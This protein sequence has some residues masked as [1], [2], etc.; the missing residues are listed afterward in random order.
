MADSSTVIA[1]GTVDTWIE[2]LQALCREVQAW[3]ESSGWKTRIILKTITET[4]LGRYRAPVLIMEKDAVEMVLNPVARYVPG[5]EGAVDLYLAPAYDDVATLYYEQST[6]YLHIPI[7]SQ[8]HMPERQ[9]LTSETFLSVLAEMS[10][11]G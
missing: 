10:H 3:A 6:W 9:P 5:A 11:R 8:P 7:Q 1:N 2:Q 4:Q